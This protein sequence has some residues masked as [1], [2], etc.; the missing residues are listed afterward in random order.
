[1][2]CKLHFDK[3]FIDDVTGD[4]SVH[5]GNFKESTR[6]DEPITCA[7]ATQ[8]FAAAPFGAPMRPLAGS[9]TFKGN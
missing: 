7:N 6:V 5:D 2:D 8:D 3:F 1:M 4:F 9:I